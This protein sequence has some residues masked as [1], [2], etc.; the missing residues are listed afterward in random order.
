MSGVVQ[1]GGASVYSPGLVGQPTASGRRFRPTEHV[2]ASKSLPL[3][4]TARV[5]NLRTGR[6][7][8]VEVVDRGPY[9]R[10]RII[11]LSPAAASALGMDRH[12]IAYVMVEPVPA[13]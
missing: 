5:T 13:R 1:H 7:A 8:V 10:G 9:V 4:S 3:G 12:G 6:S 11:D 2:A